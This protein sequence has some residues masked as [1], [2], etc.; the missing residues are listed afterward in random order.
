MILYLHGFASCGNSTKTKLLKHYFGKENVIAPDLLVDPVE[1]VDFIRRVA[2]AV[3]VLVDTGEELHRR[4]TGLDEA[5]LV[6]RA[7]VVGHGLY[8]YAGEVARAAEDVGPFISRSRAEDEQG[9]VTEATHRVEVE[10]GDGTLRGE[11]GMPDIMTRTQAAALL[12]REGDEHQRS[13]QGPAL[14]CAGQFQ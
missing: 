5:G 1:A 3:D 8:R 7:D 11:A 10:H 2:G 6:A 12:T 14:K 9:A 13:R 4:D